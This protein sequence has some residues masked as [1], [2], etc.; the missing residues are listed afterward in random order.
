ME[1]TELGD[2]A[3]GRRTVSIAG[4]GIAGLTVGALLAKRGWGVTIYERGSGIR[5][6]GAGIV[7]HNNMA[8]V[9]E[10]LGV[11]DRLLRGAEQFEWERLCDR[12]GKVLRQKNLA[13]S[14][15]RY[16]PLRQSLVSGLYSAA[17]ELGAKIV[18]GAE[19][20]SATEGG[21]ICLA[22][23]TSRRSDLVI[24]AD[25]F[26]SAVRSSLGLTVKAVS[27]S[28]GA[29][30]VLIPRGEFEAEPVVWEFWSGSRRLGIAPTTADQ[31]YVYLACPQSD[32]RGCALPIDGDYWQSA[33]PTLPADLFKR[34]AAASGTRNAYPFVQCRAW[35]KGRVAIIGDAAHALPPTL[36][37]GAGLAVSNARALVGALDATSDMRAAL[38]KWEAQY[39]GVTELTQRW[40]RRYDAMST[41]LARVP[42]AR[43]VVIRLFR[44]PWLDRRLHAADRVTF[45]VATPSPAPPVPRK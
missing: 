11:F 25:G 37:Q 6:I 43:A 32:R 10:E 42:S 26:R 35:S 40:A 22:D 23:G 1:V 8:L 7:V 34:L 39:R 28:N 44:V 2:A 9:F 30:R 21:E 31:T 4:A 38:E 12:H 3:A 33:F 13:G 45:G 24:A 16:N 41:A 27:L 18:T 15:R 17:V 5:E 14:A 36:G 20:V 19:V 29:T